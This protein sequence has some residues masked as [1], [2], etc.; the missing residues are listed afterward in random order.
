M[1]PFHLAFPVYD[2]AETR[3]FFEELLGCSVGR[4]SDRWIDFDFWGHQLVVHKVASDQLAPVATNPVDDEQVPA[5]HF[6][7][8]LSW[9]AFDELVKR[10][11]DEQL[12]Y[13]IPPTTRFE[14]RQGEQR[15][16]FV[17][18][19]AGNHLE[20]KCFRNPHMLFATDGLDYP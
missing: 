10:L 9:D 2:L 8:V 4:T 7:A 5:S 14:G 16:F 13:V 20:F 6:G 11:E 12:P 17:K 1:Q 15:T 3:H 19:P 18:D